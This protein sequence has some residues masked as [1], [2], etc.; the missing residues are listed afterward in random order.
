MEKSVFNQLKK[1]TTLQENH[2]N[3]D[4]QIGEFVEGNLKNILT[5]ITTD[6]GWDALD[7]FEKGEYRVYI[8]L[9]DI[10]NVVA[11]GETYTACTIIYETKD[12]EVY[13]EV[14]E[15]DIFIKFSDIEPA[16]Q[17]EIILDIVKK[18]FAY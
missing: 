15:D 5:E 11:D 1:L 12:D 10:H 2:E 7:E 13:L 8:D 4:S 18:F 17:L 3:V 9:N 16:Q 6:G 14:E